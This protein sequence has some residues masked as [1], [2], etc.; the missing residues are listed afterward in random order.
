M[1]ILILQLFQGR[2]VFK[3][4]DPSPPNLAN[5]AAIPLFSCTITPR[6][7]SREMQKHELYLI[8]VDIRF[9]DVHRP[10]NIAQCGTCYAHQLLLHCCK[11]YV[12]LHNSQL[13]ELSHFSWLIT[14]TVSMYLVYPL[15]SI[16]SHH[17]KISFC[18]AFEVLAIC[19]WNS[20]HGNLC[21]S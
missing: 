18:T 19:T 21:D 2:M 12:S 13:W 20:C 17:S 9:L 10:I 14:V 5:K 8:A 3:V 6:N 15:L 4:L 7:F 1:H 16:I 11:Y